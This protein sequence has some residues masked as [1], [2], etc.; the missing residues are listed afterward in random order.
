M[1]TTATPPTTATPG[2]D[3]ENTSGNE[4]ENTSGDDL[5]EDTPA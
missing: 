2:N 5:K 1:T 4:D 3:D